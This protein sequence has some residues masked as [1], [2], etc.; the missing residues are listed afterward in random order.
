ME[1]RIFCLSPCNGTVASK[2]WVL[3]YHLTAVYF[4]KIVD[5]MVCI[6]PLI[7]RTHFQ[8]A[9][10]NTETLSLPVL[11]KKKFFFCLLSFGPLIVILK[12][13]LKRE[14]LSLTSLVR[15]LNRDA[16]HDLILDVSCPGTLQFRTEGHSIHARIF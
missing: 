4:L 13:S 7:N 16:S 12:P 5:S 10:E 1:V 15:Q 14:T 9:F 6:S 11:T 8:E 3:K 2:G